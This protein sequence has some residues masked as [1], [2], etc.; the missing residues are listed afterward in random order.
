VRLVIEQGP[1][2]GRSVTL[3]RRA[4]VV[5]RGEASDLRLPETGVSRQHVR[6][7]RGPQGWEV[8][9]LGSTN[10]TFVN[11]RRLPAHQP[12]VLHQGDQ[13]ALGNAAR[14]T[15]VVLTVRAEEPEAAVPPEGRPPGAS[16]RGRPRSV[17]M[18]VGAVALI[19]VLVGLVIVVVTL[20]QPEPEPP[21]PTVAGPLDQIATVLPVPTGF[22]GVMTSVA[23]LLPT[24]FP[25]FPLEATETPTPGAAVPGREMV[26]RAR[27]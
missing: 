24:S 1:L 21:T 5:G 3:V 14:T 19:V 2:A 25:L 15:A 10:G 17:V 13:I 23:T 18:V 26:Q 20:L 7:Q 16:E 12:L 11:G 27:W 6:F 22:E 4:V 8:V 9:D